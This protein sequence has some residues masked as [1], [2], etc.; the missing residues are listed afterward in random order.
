MIQTMV[1]LKGVYIGVYKD[2]KGLGIGLCGFLQS[3]VPF[4][5][6]P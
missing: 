2:K 3:D 6:S 1:T 5:G 4:W